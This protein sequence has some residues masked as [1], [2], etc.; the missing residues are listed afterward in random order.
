MIKALMAHMLIIAG[1]GTVC[2]DQHV[3][4]GQQQPH[5]GAA[6]IN[7]CNDQPEHAMTNLAVAGTPPCAMI[8]L[9]GADG[10]HMQSE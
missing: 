7:M 4:H 3:G 5:R 10:T 9:A 2:N 1:G 6:M 8:N